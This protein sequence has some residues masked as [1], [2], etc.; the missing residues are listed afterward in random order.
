[1]N[2][3]IYI[4]ACSIL[5]PISLTAQSK[6]GIENYYYPGTPGSNGVV[7][8]VHF[9]TNHAWRGELRY[10]YEDAATISL[11]AGKT[12]T[13]GKSLKW[14]ISPMIGVSTGVFTGISIATNI[15]AEWKNLYLSSQ[16]QY[17]KSTKTGC[18]NFL[19]SWS[20]IG[21]N[22]SDAVFAGVAFQYTRSVN[23][24]ILEP[25]FVG[26]FSI[27]NI[28]VPLYAFSPFGAGRYF[29]AGVIYECQFK[30]RKK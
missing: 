24:N 27:G 20:E 15:E 10:N 30:R 28:T 29:V 12:I 11:F 18:Y 9:E 3:I 2:R 22:I 19:F 26:G 14:S 4:I 5:L 1:M 25:G 8:V 23:D 21:Y 17:S 13:A 6:L 7:P 16:N